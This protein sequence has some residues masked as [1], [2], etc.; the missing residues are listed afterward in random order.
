MLE[1][2]PVITIDGPSGSGKGT[3][4]SRVAS[5]LSYHLLDSG[6]LYRIL[7]IATLK[8]GVA[9]NNEPELAKLAKSLDIAF[10]ENGSGSVSLDGDDVS[11]EIRSDRGSDMASRVGAIPAARDALFERQLAFLQPPGLVAD[12]RDMGTVVFPDAEVKI[13]LTA[14]PEERARRR[15]KQLIGKGIDAILPALLRELKERD[16]RDSKREVSPL[17]PAED[18]L[19]LDTT[20]L[21]IDEVVEEVLNQAKIAGVLSK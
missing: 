4:A 3:I 10:G 6:A 21:S 13:Y 18:A 20:D 19:V 9:L 5:E 2:P 8:H 12:G 16:E 7:G 15:Y 17:V 1:K 11:L 14:S